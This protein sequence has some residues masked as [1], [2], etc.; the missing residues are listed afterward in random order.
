MRLAVLVVLCFAV[1]LSHNIQ[2]TGLEGGFI[3]LINTIFDSSATAAFFSPSAGQQV[4]RLTCGNEGGSISPSGPRGTLTWTINNIPTFTEIYVKVRFGFIDSWE[5]EEAYITVNGVDIWRK[6]S[7]TDQ[8]AHNVHVCGRTERT[9]ELVTI[10]RRLRVNQPSTQLTIVIGSNLDQPVDNEFF[11]ISEFVVY[12]LAGNG[13]PAPTG[14][15]VNVANQGSWQNIYRSDLQLGQPSPW[16]NNNNQAVTPFVCGAEGPV[17]RQGG[18]GNY[19]QWISTV[20][21]FAATRVRVSLR[22]GFLD[23][24]DGE[25]AW[26]SVNGKEI[27]RETSKA[28]EAGVSA[29]AIADSGHTANVC[30]DGS[31]PPRSNDRFLNVNQESDIALPANGMVTVRVG[32]GLDQDI[33]NESFVISN[34]QI[35]VLRQ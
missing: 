13:S 5:N 32:S 8:G 34:V 25:A 31:R 12:A 24:W 21:P 6:R 14:G 18:K 28:P 33:D 7:T 10:E 23:S 35:E 1:A 17:V 26:I 4:R 29:Q 3:E 27:W 11:A 9:D 16:R 15:A 19:V 30:G 2:W 20:L 22:L